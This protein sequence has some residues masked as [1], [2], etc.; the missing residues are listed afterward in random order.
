MHEEKG[1]KF[2]LGAEVAEMIGDDEGNLTEV[3]LTNG[4]SL[5]A[6]LLLAGLG[7]VPSTDFLRASDITLDSRGYVPVD[8]V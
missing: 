3:A 5:A 1:V 4:Q 8:Q 6:D 7:V 2:V